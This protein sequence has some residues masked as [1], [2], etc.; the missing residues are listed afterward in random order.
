MMVCIAHDGHAGAS[1][2]RGA[3]CRRMHKTSELLAFDFPDRF[4]VIRSSTTI[5]K[6]AELVLRPAPCFDCLCITLNRL[7]TESFLQ[8]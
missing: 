3:E 2:V 7:T 1:V 5:L 4:A 8:E 6:P